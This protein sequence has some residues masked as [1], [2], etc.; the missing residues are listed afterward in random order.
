MRDDL[1]GKTSHVHHI[2]PQSEFLPIAHSIENLI[3]LTA[4]QHQDKA[5]PNGDTAVIVKI[6]QI[7]CLLAKSKTIKASEQKGPSIYSRL[8]FIKVLNVGF[9]LEE[10]KIDF[11]SNFEEINEKIYLFYKME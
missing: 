8:N 4:G 9:K 1:Y 7:I 2:F 10:D 11:N 5:H 3:A 6:Y